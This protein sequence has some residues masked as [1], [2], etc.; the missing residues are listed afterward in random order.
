[1]IA[2][3][4]LRLSPPGATVAPGGD[5]RKVEDAIKATL[6]EVAKSGV[7]NAE[8]SRAKSQI[9][10]AEIRSRDG[11]YPFASSLGAAVASADWKWFVGYVDAV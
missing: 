11:T 3:S 8:L 2:S 1:M 5:C 6:Y 7:T 9:E 4:T 10:V